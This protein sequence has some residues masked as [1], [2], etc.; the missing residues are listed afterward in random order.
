MKSWMIIIL[1][2]VFLMTNQSCKQ[3]TEE[4]TVAIVEESIP[5]S[6]FN[7]YTRFHNDSIFQI[8]RIAF[9]IPEIEQGENYTKENWILNR[10]FSVDGENYKREIQN[11]HGII[12]EVIYH[13]QGVFTLERRF[14]KLNDDAWHLIYYNVSNELDENWVK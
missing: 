8:E 4:S 5:E 11:V 2:M 6:F 3:K 12:H 1:F 13:T 14:T 7:F 9:P 10:S